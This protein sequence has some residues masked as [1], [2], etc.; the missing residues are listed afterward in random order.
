MKA[1]PKIIIQAYYQHNVRCLGTNT[2]AVNNSQDSASPLEPRNPI[3]AGPRH[4][5][6]AETWGKD[7]Q[8]TFM[9]M[10]EVLQVET[11]KSLKEIQENVNK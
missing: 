6:I 4:S 9:V 10:T 8:P 2:K 1:Y 11:N 3:P 7:L 5:N